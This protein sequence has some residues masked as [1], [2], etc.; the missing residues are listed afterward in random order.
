MITKF[1]IFETVNSDHLE[2]IKIGDYVILSHMM[3]KDG[4]P[5]IK[6]ENKIG[7]LTRVRQHYNEIDIDFSKDIGK[8]FGVS[9]F[10]IR[11]WSSDKEALEEFIAAKKYN[12]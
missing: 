7:K 4:Q 6:F 2:N 1:K 8:M 5:L 10:N 11:F 12:I 9:I 3:Y